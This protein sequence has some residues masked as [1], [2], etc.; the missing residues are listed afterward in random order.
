MGL[1]PGLIVPQSCGHSP[2]VPCV[3]TEC[4]PSLNVLLKL[5]SPPPN[6]YALFIF[7]LMKFHLFAFVDMYVPWID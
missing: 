5:L 3:K 7:L 2:Y 4:T 6:N 1:N